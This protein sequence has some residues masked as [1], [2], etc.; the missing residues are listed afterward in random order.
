MKLRETLCGLALLGM[1][2]VIVVNAQDQ[3][4]NSP[5]NPAASLGSAG[6][7]GGY[8]Q[9]PAPAARGVSAGD[10]QPYDP[11]QVTPDTNTLAGAQLLGVG[12]LEHTRNIF[13]PS[14]SFTEQGQTFPSVPGQ[15]NQTDLFSATLVGGGLNFD[16]T[17][18]RYHLDHHLQRRRKFYPG[19]SIFKCPVSRVECNARNRMGQ[20]AAAPA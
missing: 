20:M 19:F 9:R 18:S 7:G 3:N 10:S 16:R 4:P 15:S 8:A 6:L 11:S 14:L 5:A 17:W 1:T 12:S 2:C 13:D